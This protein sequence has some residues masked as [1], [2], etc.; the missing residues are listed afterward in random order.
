[1]L[2]PQIIRKGGATGVIPVEERR[3]ITVIGTEAILS[4]F[5]ETCLRQA[6]NAA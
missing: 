2:N 3:P 4:S 1:M 5:D 6:M